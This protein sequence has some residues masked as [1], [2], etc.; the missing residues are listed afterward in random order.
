MVNFADIYAEMAAA[1]AAVIAPDEA[2]L[3]ATIA[4]LF[5]DRPR[6]AAMGQAALAFAQ[7]QGDQLGGRDGPDPAAAAGGMRLATPRWWYVR[8]GAPAPLTRALL[9]PAA[10]VWTW[11]TRYRIANARPFDRRR[12]GDLRRQPDAGR[13]RQDAGGARR[14]APARRRRAAARMC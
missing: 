1:G 4:E 5:A 7:A 3:A 8:D 2:A 6:I 12:A 14:R 11:A 10:W 9:R 13:Q